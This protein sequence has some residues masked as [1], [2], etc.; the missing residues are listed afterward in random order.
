MVCAWTER[1]KAACRWGLGGGFGVVAIAALDGLSPSPLPAWAGPAQPV[2]ASPR[3][4]GPA[5]RAARGPVQHPQ[6]VDQISN[7]SQP[8][9]GP[10]HSGA[11]GRSAPL[12][13]SALGRPSQTPLA[14][15]QGCSSRRTRVGTLRRDA[16]CPGRLVQRST[17]RSAPK[18]WPKRRR[19]ASAAAAYGC[20]AAHQVPISRDRI[21]ERAILSHTHTTNQ[22][23]SSPPP[24]TPAHFTF[25]LRKQSGSSRILW[26]GQRLTLSVGTGRLAFFRS[27]RFV[28]S[29]THRADSSLA[30]QHADRAI[31]FFVVVQHEH[32]P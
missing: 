25:S 29:A 22:P 4:F 12:R 3:Q 17:R 15:R 31:T 7:V 18:L 23:L 27:A 30:Q 5:R 32:Y 13:S 16:I 26:N 11:V 21:A 20:P 24:Q 19:D 10:G 28:H 9:F 1:K 6:Q 2:G 14:T 8:G